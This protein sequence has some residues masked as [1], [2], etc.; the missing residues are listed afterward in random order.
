MASPQTRAALGA[1]APA[2]TVGGAQGA[3]NFMRRSWPALGFGFLLAFSSSLGQTYFIGLFGA[4]IRESLSLSHGA[5][6]AVY[7][8]ATLASAA[9]LV[10]AGKLVDHVR[11]RTA[12]LITFAGLAA[13]AVLMAHADTVALLA[14][15]LFGLRLGGQGMLSH[16]ALTAMARWFRRERGRA[17]ALATLGFPA[18]EGLLPP[19]V[20]LGLAHSGPRE[21]W[22][23]SALI[24]V[25]VSAPLAVGLAARGRRDGA[26]TEGTQSSTNQ[27]AGEAPISW[28]RRQVLRDPRFFALLPGLLTPPFVVT[29]LLF[30]QS[31]LV[32]LNGW[33]LPGFAALFPLF[34]ISAVVSGLTIGALA[35]RYGSRRV[36]PGF[37][38]PLGL[39]VLLFSLTDTLAVAGVAMALAGITAGGATVLFGTLWIELYGGVHLGAI[40]GVTTALMVFATALAPGIMGA[41]IDAGLGLDMQF[42]AFAVYIL[43]CSVGFL[44]LQPALI[45]RSP[46]AGRD[47]NPSHQPLRYDNP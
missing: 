37:L 20:A 40:R 45:N 39:S 33:T 7:S 1:A 29:G 47:P 19:L 46:S 27:D 36:L 30:H 12:A 2:M 42:Q 26:A 24:L 25:A 34:A 44:F 41:L 22:L 35:D 18:A 4:G 15:A 6:G 13:S 16:I 9:A 38:L 17:V 32:E 8:A 11:A 31:R 14:L 21:V 5:F 43:L 28:T 3:V 10:F 23:A